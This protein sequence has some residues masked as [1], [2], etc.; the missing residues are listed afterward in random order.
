[1]AVVQVGALVEPQAKIEIE[2]MAIVPEA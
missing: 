1:M 2:T